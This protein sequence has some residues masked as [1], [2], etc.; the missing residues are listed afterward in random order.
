M[1][2]KHLRI[3]KGMTFNEQFTLKWKEQ[4]RKD[5]GYYEPIISLNK[6]FKETRLM[7]LERINNYT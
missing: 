6:L 2:L 5:I 4:F 1:T 3:K 7:E